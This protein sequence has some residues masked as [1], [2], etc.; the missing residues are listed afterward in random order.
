MVL[1]AKLYNTRAGHSDD[2]RCPSRSTSKF[3]WGCGGPPPGMVFEY[4]ALRES[5]L[6]FNSFP[7][8]IKILLFV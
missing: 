1:I 2:A 7:D 6:P 8:T 5:L 3:L 4:Y